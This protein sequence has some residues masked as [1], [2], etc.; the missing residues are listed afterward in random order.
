LSDGSQNQP[1]AREKRSLPPCMLKSEY[2]V[3]RNTGGAD[4]L[5]PHG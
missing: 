3:Y 4:R 1:P 2:F 5:Y